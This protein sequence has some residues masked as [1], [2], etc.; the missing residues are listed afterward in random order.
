MERD[1]EIDLQIASSNLEATLNVM[2][3]DLLHG[4]PQQEVCP[5]VSFKGVQIYKSTLVSEL[6]GNPHLSKDRLTR[7]KQSIYF[8]NLV[9]KPTVREGAATMF[10]TVGSD[11]GVFFVDET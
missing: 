4:A 6:V 7:V 11:C 5:F 9:D 3:S 8:N 2:H 10:M 1:R